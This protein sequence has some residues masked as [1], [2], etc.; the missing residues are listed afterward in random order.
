M[1]C[2]ETSNVWSIWEVDEAFQ[3]SIG[4]SRR[5][6]ASTGDIRRLQEAFEGVRRRLEASGCVCMRYQ[7]ACGADWASE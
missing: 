5:L 4:I 2:K 6:E 1:M 7:E 3:V